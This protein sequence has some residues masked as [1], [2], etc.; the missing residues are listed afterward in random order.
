MLTKFQPK[1]YHKAILQA[2]NSNSEIYGDYLL[3]E[4][5]RLA[6]LIIVKV[7]RPTDW[8]NSHPYFL[9]DRLEDVSAEFANEAQD[10]NSCHAGLYGYVRGASLRPPP[11]GPRL[12]IAGCNDFSLLLAIPQADPCP[13]LNQVVSY[14][15]RSAF[16][17]PS[18]EATARKFVKHLSERDRKI[19]AP[20]SNIGG[21]LFDH[22]AT[23][24]DLGGSHHLSNSSRLTGSTGQNTHFQQSGL[25]RAMT[26]ELEK[27]HFIIPGLQ[28]NLEDHS[29][30]MLSGAPLISSRASLD[31]LSSASDDS[32][33]L[34]HDSEDSEEEA[35]HFSAKEDG[36]EKINIER[37][38]MDIDESDT[39]FDSEPEA[40]IEIFS[41]GTLTGSTR[42][43]NEI[44]DVVSG[45]LLIRSGSQS[46]TTVENPHNPLK[47]ASFL[48]GYN[49]YGDDVTMPL[50]KDLANLLSSS[51][52]HLIG[53]D[54]VVGNSTGAPAF[55]SW[56]QADR[57]ILIADLFTTGVW[58]PDEDFNSILAAD[59]RARE[60]M[61]SRQQEQTNM[62]LSRHKLNGN[63]DSEDG[64]DDD[65]ED[66]EEE[67][68]DNEANED[69]VFL[70][71][72]LGRRRGIKKV[73][74]DED[75][76][77]DSAKDEDDIID[78]NEDSPEVE[79]P[80]KDYEKV[81]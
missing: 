76:D 29:I 27:A 45:G 61:E 22:D 20:M 70:R 24:I 69:G 59:S 19:Y 65:D 48:N 74:F 77:Y 41:G 80:A 72:T 14:D 53:K 35:E 7:P 6:R 64:D 17:V 68:T 75:S 2:S 28:E 10:P 11:G 36:D 23:Y 51:T 5:R 42:T 4:V 66:S 32:L 21:V 15:Q 50:S 34:I 13:T 37:E 78:E 63:S 56:C 44:E 39:N 25:T 38:K 62:K 30:Q 40:G 52:N 55:E 3:A 67:D 1:K 46:S 58:A 79:D 8:R 81:I 26:V 9:I 33:S 12:H 54:S 18:Q 43:C 16:G 49:V 71:D 60:E 57:K 73:R 47:P 31:S